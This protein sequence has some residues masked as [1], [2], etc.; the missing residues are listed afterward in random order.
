[1]E[2]EKPP[3]PAEVGDLVSV[4]DAT[5]TRAWSAPNG[6]LL[7]YAG[8]KN[9]SRT[10]PA[11]C[12]PA[13]RRPRP[14]SDSPANVS[15]SDVTFGP[16][17]R[18][19][20]G[21]SGSGQHDTGAVV[22]LTRDAHAYLLRTWDQDTVFPNGFRHPVAVSASPETS[23][24]RRCHPTRLLRVPAEARGTKLTSS[25]ESLTRAGRVRVVAAPGGHS[26]TCWRST[27]MRT[28]QPTIRVPATLERARRCLDEWRQVDSVSEEDLS[29][30]G[31]FVVNT[32][33]SC[34]GTFWAVSQSGVAWSLTG[35]GCSMLPAAAIPATCST[36]A[37]TM[38]GPSSVSASAMARTSSSPSPAT[39]GRRTSSAAKRAKRAPQ[40]PAEYNAYGPSTFA[41]T[42]TVTYPW[43]P[44][45]SITVL[46]HR[47]PDEECARS[48]VL[49]EWRFTQQ[50]LTALEP[51]HGA[52]SGSN[53][54]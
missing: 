39:A 12:P 35:S 31:V 5:P 10:G 26:R 20:F 48:Q 6:Y 44:H 33:G 38:T 46:R 7:E 13:G 24:W 1:M 4:T 47:H 19:T 9:P 51:G 32:G 41:L 49:D 15:V 17:S 18:H 11:G 34:S 40:R 14:G 54:H 27:T 50:R 22:M 28:P 21:F 42:Y 16:N 29:R 43:W 36:T 25:A 2:C 53:P 8:R 37:F 3:G 23:S 45:R 52:S 30:D